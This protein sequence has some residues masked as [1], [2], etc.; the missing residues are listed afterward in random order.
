MVFRM[1][2]ADKSQIAARMAQARQGLTDCLILI[3]VSEA[4]SRA[5]VSRAWFATYSAVLALLETLPAPR[6][7]P[8][9]EDATLA[10]FLKQFVQPG[11]IASKTDEMIWQL[12]E[13]RLDADY[14]SPAPVSIDAAHLAAQLG[15]RVYNAIS[16]WL[17]E[18]GLLEEEK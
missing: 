6:P 4:A 15:G 8:D 16:A 9:A 14:R 3:G 12:R 7:Q 1:A 17:F 18:Q 13:M 2:E 5:A 10:L 11:V